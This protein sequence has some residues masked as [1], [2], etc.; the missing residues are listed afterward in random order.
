[1][2]IERRRFI[3]DEKIYPESSQRA[4]AGDRVNLNYSA[5]Y[6]NYFL[7]VLEEHSDFAGD[8]VRGTNSEGED[9]ITVYIPY[10]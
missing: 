8:N 1:M 10:V 2:F 5:W 3:P 9:L 4:R 6:Y 7:M